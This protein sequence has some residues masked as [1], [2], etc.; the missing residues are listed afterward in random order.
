MDAWEDVAHLVAKQ[1]GIALNLPV[2]VS[3]LRGE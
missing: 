2:E 3:V 1:F